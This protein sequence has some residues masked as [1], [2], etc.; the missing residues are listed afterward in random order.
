MQQG[1][2]EPG[3]TFVF[4]IINTIVI[5]LLLRHFL[6]KPVT[7]FMA[8][9]TQSIE[10][11]LAGA[12]EKETEALALKAQYEEKLAGVREERNEML[13]EAAR[14]GEERGEILIQ[15]AREEIRKMEERSRL[16]LEREKTKAINEFKNQISE[17]AVLAAAQIME[18][19]L[20]Q[21]KHDAMI[22]KFI[23]KVGR[24][25]WQH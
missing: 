22:Q 11:Q 21:Q 15:E 23:E 13:K 17:L 4:Q 24:E 19:E 1:L 16:D 2:V 12:Q 18:Q 14:K 6:F 25:K 7:E 3:W 5:F 10:D 9:R 20:D 8:K